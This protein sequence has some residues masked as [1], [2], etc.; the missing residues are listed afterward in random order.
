VVFGLLE[1]VEW[2]IGKPDVWLL[3]GLF[4]ARRS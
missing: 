3:L 2:S 1:E 4:S